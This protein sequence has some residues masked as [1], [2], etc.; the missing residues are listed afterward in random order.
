MGWFSLFQRSGPR[1]RVRPS[2]ENLH[3]LTKDA[4]ALLITNVGRAAAHDVVVSIRVRHSAFQFDPVELL[5][6]EA[7]APLL[8]SSAGGRFK[9]EQMTVSAHWF[10]IALRAIVQDVKETLRIPLTIRYR[11]DQGTIRTS[12]A[13]LICDEHLRLRVTD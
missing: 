5:D 8:H 7:E 1:L 11:D 9:L 6:S 2:V 10:R 3:A 4:P 13:M 12:Y